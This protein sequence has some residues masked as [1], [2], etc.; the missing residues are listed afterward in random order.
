VPV[1]V[2]VETDVLAR[3][4]GSSAE[5][6]PRR[7]DGVGWDEARMASGFVLEG[8]DSRIGEGEGC[9]SCEE[10]DSNG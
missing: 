10:E 8:R 9:R 7:I 5:G 1:A 2:T 3:M 6:I 4:A